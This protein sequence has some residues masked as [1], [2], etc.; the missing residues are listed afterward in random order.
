M[1]EIEKKPKSSILAYRITSWTWALAPEF[2]FRSFRTAL[3]FHSGFRFGVA[4][5]GLRLD[6]RMYFFFFSCPVCFS[7]K[8]LT[9]SIIAMSRWR[10]FGAPRST[11]YRLLPLFFHSF[12]LWKKNNHAKPTLNARNAIK[13]RRII[14]FRNHRP[15]LI[16]SKFAIRKYIAS[17]PFSHVSPV[18]QNYIHLLSRIRL[19]F[20][21]V[22]FDLFYCSP[23]CVPIRR[24]AVD[25]PRHRSQIE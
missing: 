16:N 2:C 6:F 9:H 12:M 10:S 18:E 1:K 24:Y 21:F 23:I 20:L 8:R 19:R 13:D 14:S 5:R 3:S 15:A 11:R 22:S 7:Y 17:P 4:A 25:R